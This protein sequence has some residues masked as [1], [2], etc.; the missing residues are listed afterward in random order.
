M[1][2]TY[3]HFLWKCNVVLIETCEK[4]SPLT[5]QTQISPGLFARSALFNPAQ[6][7]P[8]ALHFLPIVLTLLVPNHPRTKH[9]RRCFQIQHKIRP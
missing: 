3:L 6:R 7:C 5:H 2:A 8:I 9:I 1:Y 4:L